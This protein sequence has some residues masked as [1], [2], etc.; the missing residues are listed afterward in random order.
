MRCSDG[1]VWCG[2][3]YGH[4]VLCVVGLVCVMSCDGVCGVCDVGGVYYV[5]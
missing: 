1:L 5:V 4:G 3:R 2:V